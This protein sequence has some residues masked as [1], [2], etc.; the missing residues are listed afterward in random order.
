MKIIFTL[1]TVQIVALPLLCSARCQDCQQRVQ[2]GDKRSQRGTPL[3]PLPS[4]ET[5][6]HQGTVH[7][8]LLKTSDERKGESTQVCCRIENKTREACNFG[9]FARADFISSV[10][11]LFSCWG[12]KK[13]K[14]TSLPMTL[15]NKRNFRIVWQI[16][17][18]KLF[19]FLL[20]HSFTKEHI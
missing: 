11:L 2:S 19:I 18:P 16:F 6:F 12:G 14:E 5:F 7:I 4:R 20:S 1:L 13:W 17:K 3:A 15:L 9:H 10:Q 8:L